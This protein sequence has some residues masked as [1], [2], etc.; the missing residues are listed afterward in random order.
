[1]KLSDLHV[2]DSC[3]GAVGLQFYVIRVSVAMVM[4]REANQVLGLAQMLGGR[5]GLA[6]VFAPDDNAVMVFGDEDKSLMDELLICT[7]C[8][9]RDVHLAWIL[10]RRLSAKEEDVY[11]SENSSPSGE[12]GGVGRK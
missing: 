12:R 11:R 1:M 9:Q 10:E 4:A 5:L 8:F 6:E 3:G 7:N 2:C